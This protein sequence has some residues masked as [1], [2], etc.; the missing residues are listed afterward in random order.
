MIDYVINT[1]N[2]YKMLNQDDHIV[3]G[4]SGGADSV[5]LLY[6]LLDL[7]KIYNFKITA[8]HVNH[9]LRGEESQRDE[10]FVINLCHNLSVDLE[11]FKHPIL[12][13]SKKLKLSVEEAGRLIR[14]NSFK[15]VLNKKI[16][17][18]IAVAHN[19]N[20]QAETLLMNFFRGSGLKGLSGIPAVRGNIIRPLIECSRQLIE[21][22]CKENNINY[23]FDSSNGSLDYTRNKV[24]LELLPYIIKEFNFNVVD[25]L[26]RSAEIF[27]SEDEYIHNLS[28][29]AY[30]DCVTNKDNIQKIDIDKFLNLDQ[31]LQRRIIRIIFLN[32]SE[33]LKNFTS[34]HINMVLSL[35]N[36]TT[37]KSISLPYGLKAERSYNNLCIFKPQ[38]HKDYI[39]KITLG[40]FMYIK[41]FDI[42]ISCQQKKLLSKDG[43]TNTCTKVFNYD[44][45]TSDIILR[46]RKPGDK[47]NLKSIGNKKIKDYFINKKIPRNERNNIPMLLDNKN[48]LWILPYPST[49][50][51]QA[52]SNYFYA[53]KTDLNKL[54]IQLWEENK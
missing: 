10:D 25:T 33:T 38:V 41:E 35:T 28:L 50:N 18:K 44:K 9:L 14:Y 52:I 21:G 45:I 4:L 51:H 13:E 29:E 19:S 54:Y 48:V 23:I 31:V 20:D 17:N 49:S 5:S 34:E 11:V 27:S 43:F 3:L 8:V 22:Y 2:K 16:A 6:V 15:E 26:S 39:Y 36:N 37:G 1:V 53:E 42:Y 40:S 12:E 24:R 47:I 46:N 32:Y 30:K 7:K